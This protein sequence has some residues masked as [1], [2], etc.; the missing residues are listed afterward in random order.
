MAQSRSFIG[1]KRSRWGSHGF[2]QPAAEQPTQP[3]AKQQGNEIGGHEQ[4]LSASD[5]LW[6]TLRHLPEPD[7]PAEPGE[8]LHQ[9]RAAGAI[10]VPDIDVIAGGSRSLVLSSRFVVPKTGRRRG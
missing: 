2:P 4:G 10:A 1:T 7:F 6:R 5:K 9:P 8:P 3:P